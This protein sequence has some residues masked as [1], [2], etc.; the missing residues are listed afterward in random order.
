MSENSFPKNRSFLT[1]NFFFWN[2][3]SNIHKCS[4]GDVKY[5]SVT[6]TSREHFWERETVAGA[7]EAF[8]K[9]KSHEACHFFF[10]KKSIFFYQKIFFWNQASDIPKCFLDVQKRLYAT[11]T[12]GKHFWGRGTVGKAQEAFTKRKAHETSFW[13]WPEIQKN[14]SLDSFSALNLS[15]VKIFW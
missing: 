10:P 2:Q 11:E 14:P 8:T 5:L 4:P 3:A 1:K 9:G 13:L 6:E 7:Q 12:L 15:Q